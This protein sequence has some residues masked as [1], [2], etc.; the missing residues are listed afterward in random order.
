MLIGFEGDRSRSTPAADAAF[1]PDRLDR[2][3]GDLIAKL[4]PLIS[5]IARGYVRLKTS[6]FETIDS[7]PVLYVSNHNGGIAGPDVA[8]TLA[9]LWNALGPAHPVYALAHDF[10]MRHVPAFGTLIQR[11]GALRAAPEN[12]ERALSAGAQVL[13]YPGGDLEA[14]RASHRRDEIVLGERTGFVKVAQRT[15]VPIVPIVA[16]GAHRSAY[17]LTDGEA[18]ARRL[19][20]KRWAR[21]ER[22]PIALSLPWGI[23]IGPWIPYLPLP[24]PIRLRKLS[25]IVA[26]PGDDPRDVREEVRAR[27]QTALDSMKEEAND[28]RGK[29]GLR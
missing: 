15:G 18:I 20:L 11:F 12:A 5:T 8:C 22:F 13:V 6:G 25:P 24:F 10:A 7:A 2:R 27:M 26:M 9:T 28:R 3:D 4:L 17:I 19:D 23:A 1:D 14:Y 29:I 21:L 16:Y